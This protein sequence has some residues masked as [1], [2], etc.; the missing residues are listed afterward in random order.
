MEGFDGES[1]CTHPL[2]TDCKQETQV[3][4]T[5]HCSLIVN[6]SDGH[7]SGTTI[8]ESNAYHD[9]DDDDDDEDVGNDEIFG[10]IPNA[11]TRLPLIPIVPT[12][13]CPVVEQ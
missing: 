6:D 5:I 8:P 12:P 10:H 3:S 7:S 4:A 1:H 11:G 13:H 9:D 2:F